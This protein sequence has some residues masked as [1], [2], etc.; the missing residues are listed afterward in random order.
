M[1]VLACGSVAEAT[2]DLP[3]P[4]HWLSAQE[5]ERCS[6]L[7]G[8][9]RQEFVAGRWFLR[10]LLVRQGIVPAHEPLAI[11][12]GGAPVLR[13]LPHLHLSLSHRAGWLVAAV[14]DG[15]VGIDVEVVV[16][17]DVTAMAE[18][19]CSVQERR[20]IQSLAAATGLLHLHTL[21][22]LKEAAYKA[23]VSAHD[24]AAFD[25]V[26]MVPSSA[27]SG[28]RSWAWPDGRVVACVAARMD[29]CEFATLWSGPAC[30]SSWSLENH[31]CEIAHH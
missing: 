9:R 31:A 19:I 22:A 14:A 28:A 26:E 18:R 24:P 17:R 2:Q 5:Q 11:S 10:Q 27:Q 8:R 3:E 15:P 12:V 21:W 20:H 23:G 30:I 13:G 7:G 1:L 25:Q 6:D 16:P 4:M 29:G